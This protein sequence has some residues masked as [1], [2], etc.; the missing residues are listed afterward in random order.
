M[1][2]SGLQLC[3]MLGAAVII[4]RARNNKCA[5]HNL[6]V[7]A[8]CNSPQVATVTRSEQEYSVTDQMRNYCFVLFNGTLVF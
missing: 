3:I 2:E 8:A 4:K 6:C 7:T 5:I 1:H